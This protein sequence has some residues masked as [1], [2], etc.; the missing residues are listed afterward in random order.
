MSY[1][2]TI[3]YLKQIFEQNG[4]FELVDGD[5]VARETIN[6]AKSLCVDRKFLQAR[7]RRL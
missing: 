7:F 2:F 3:E 6:R 1:F 4:F 5:Y